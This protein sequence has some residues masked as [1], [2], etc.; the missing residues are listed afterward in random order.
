MNLRLHIR[1]TVRGG[2]IL[3][4]VWAGLWLAAGFLLFVG[5]TV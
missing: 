1:P 5:V 2:L 3:A 4:Y